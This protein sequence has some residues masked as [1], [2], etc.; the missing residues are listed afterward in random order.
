[1]SYEFNGDKYLTRGVMRSLTPS[2]Q[3]FLW[4]LIKSKQ[5]EGVTLDYLQVFK[6]QVN[7]SDIIVTHEQELPKPF[8]ETYELV[9]K[10]MLLEKGDHQNLNHLIK[11]Y[12]IDD[13]THVTML[14]AEE[15]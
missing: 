1:M 7:E 13:I 10:G 9:G 5:D 6:I 2:M 15:Y 12:V 3:L 14:L 8:K 11:L 4:D